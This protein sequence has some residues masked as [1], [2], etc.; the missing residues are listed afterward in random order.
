MKKLLVLLLA[1]S[2]FSCKKELKDYVTISGKIENSESKV[3]IIASQDINKEIK[4]NEDGTFSDTLKVSQK[5]FYSFT[6]GENRTALF[7]DNGYELEMTADAK[8]FLNKLEYKGIGAE[9]N[10]YIVKKIKFSQNDLGTPKDYF[11]LDKKEFDEKVTNL[12]TKLAEMLSNKAD[13]DSMLVAQEETGNQQMFEFLSQNY[14]AQHLIF[15]KF[16]K[17]SPSPK[18]VNY[19]NFKGGKTSLDDLKGK[20]V[21]IDVWATWCTPCLNEIPALQ[22][23]EKEFQGKNIEFVSISVDNVDGTRGSKNEWKT[24]V[25]EKNLGGMQLYADKDFQSDFMTAYNVNSIPRFIIID[26]NGNIVDFDAPRPSDPKLK[27][28]FKTFK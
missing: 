12:K 14:E 24:M 16:K 5:G 22:A 10:N 1:V 2:L 23:L 20:Y 11:M 7:L 3:L 13:L 9:T 28:L 19:E 21:Y 25:A 6:E 17:G 26:P 8:D 18:F 27:E 4:L 15:A